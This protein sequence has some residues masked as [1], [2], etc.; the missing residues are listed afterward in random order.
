MCGGWPIG[1]PGPVNSSSPAPRCLRTTR[2]AIPA[3]DA[4]ARLRMR[5]LSLHEAGHS[6]GEISLRRLLDGEAQRVEATKTEDRAP[7][8]SRPQPPGG[9]QFRV[10]TTPDAS[11]YRSSD[12]IEYTDKATLQ[13]FVHEHTVP[14]ATVRSDES[15]ACEGMHLH[16][17]AVKHSA[18]AVIVPNGYGRAGMQDVGVIPIGAPGRE[19]TG[20]AA[21]ASP[22]GSGAWR[23]GGAE[24][25]AGPGRARCV[26]RYGNRVHAKPR[27]R[28]RPVL[29]RWAGCSAGCAAAA[30]ESA[31]PTRWSQRFGSLRASVTVSVNEPSRCG[32]CRSRI[33]GSSI[34]RERR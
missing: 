28:S 32:R 11:P 14:G 34:Q 13:P 26:L 7:V 19:R 23:R 5:P 16:H 20:V 31:V 21:G 33:P 12:A 24:P 22:P 29:D 6:S 25:T 27:R 10:R 9:G 8:F 2:P 18:L 30:R 4:F 1:V 3:P 17:E 15:A